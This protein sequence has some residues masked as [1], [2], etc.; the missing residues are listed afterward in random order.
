M[1][2][3]QFAQAGLGDVV[4]ARQT[5]ASHAWASTSLS[6]AVVIRP[7]MIAARWPP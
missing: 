5:S 2:I 1:V 6:F 7:H 3:P 4:D